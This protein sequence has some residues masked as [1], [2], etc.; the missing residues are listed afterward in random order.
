MSDSWCC[1]QC[2]QPVP[3]KCDG[4]CGTGTTAAGRTG[5]VA[6]IA[7]FTVVLTFGVTACQLGAGEPSSPVDVPFTASCDAHGQ[8]THVRPDTAAARAGAARMCAATQSEIDNAP[9][10]SGWHPV[11]GGAVANQ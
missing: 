6:V 1:S 3:A 10:P 5:K 4:K 8:A 9:W 11:P 7:V 2:G